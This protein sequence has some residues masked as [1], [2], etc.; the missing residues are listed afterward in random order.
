MRQIYF[1]H[2]VSSIRLAPWRKVQ[3]LD[4]RPDPRPCVAPLVI[5]AVERQ[6]LKTGRFKLS[7][8]A[9]LGD[10]AR[11]MS[12]SEI[13]KP[14]RD[15]AHLERRLIG[16]GMS[17]RLF[18]GWRS[19]GGSRRSIRRT[20]CAGHGRS[21]GSGTH[22]RSIRPTRASCMTASTLAISPPSTDR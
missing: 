10:Q 8:D 4:R 3:R 20:R 18:D 14:D 16:G 17:W 7:A 15:G 19:M 5:A 21:C 13:V 2:P 11:Q 12:S 9:G 1:E 6:I 22:K